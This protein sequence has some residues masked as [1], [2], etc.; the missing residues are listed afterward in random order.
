MN[1]TCQEFGHHYHQVW[2][3]DGETVLDIVCC[4]CGKHDWPP[5]P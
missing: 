4:S 3:D 5:A 1:A 2:S